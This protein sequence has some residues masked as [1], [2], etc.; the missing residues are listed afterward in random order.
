MEDKKL[1]SNSTVGDK[2]SNILKN[3]GVIA[4]DKMSKES[5]CQHLAHNVVYREGPLVAINKPPGMSIGSPEGS[6]IVSL[7]PELQQVL[8]TKSDLH[9]VKGAPK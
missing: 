3:P 4:V 1:R 7:L 5:L 6:S 9:V 2:K 8:Q